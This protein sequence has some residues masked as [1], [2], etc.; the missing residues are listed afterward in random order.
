MLRFPVYHGAMNAIRRT[1][2]VLLLM[3]GGLTLDAQSW[4]RL[5]ELKPGDTVKITNT[6]G[7]EQKGTF[8]AVTDDGISLK[9]KNAEVS[10]EKA[11]VR[12]VEVRSGSRRARNV[13]IG[14]AIGVA[15]GVTVD[16]T[17]GQYLRNESGESGRAVT[18]IAPIALF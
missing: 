18:Y 17:L 4:E 15:I 13:L 1:G 11:K 9:T 8:T 10:V 2:I 14:A 7:E 16:Q 6:A 12:K 5:R 3:M